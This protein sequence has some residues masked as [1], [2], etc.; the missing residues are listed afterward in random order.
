MRLAGGGYLID[1]CMTNGVVGFIFRTALVCE[2]V[3]VLVSS[4]KVQR[5]WFSMSSLDLRRGV[6]SD[7]EALFRVLI[8]TPTDL[9]PVSR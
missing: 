4:L 5:P 9:S 2:E 8:E 1:V 3:V 7:Q 6:P